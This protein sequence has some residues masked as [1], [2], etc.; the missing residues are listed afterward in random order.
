MSPLK[1]SEGGGTL[2][3][4]TGGSGAQAW[5][6]ALKRVALTVNGKKVEI[7]VD[8]RMTLAELL[9]EKLGLTGTKV[10]CNRAECGSCSVLLDGAPVY[11]CSTLAVEASGREVETIEGL[12]VGGKLH[13]IQEAFIEH[14]AMQCGFCSPGMIMSLKASL[15]RNPHPTEEEIR[16][17]VDGNLCRCGCYPNIIKAALAA[18]EIMSR[19][20]GGRNG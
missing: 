11:S 17:M 2:Q 9:R 6:T 5:P 10:G 18:A 16:A 19:R 20:G 3:R 12:A 4:N 8:S 13:P 14:D 15:E 1:E 7:E